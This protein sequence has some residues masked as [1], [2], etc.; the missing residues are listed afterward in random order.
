MQGVTVYSSDFGLKLILPRTTYHPD[1]KI[2]FEV[3][4]ENPHGVLIEFFTLNLTQTTLTLIRKKHRFSASS[5]NLSIKS[6]TNKIASQSSGHGFHETSWFG[7]IQIPSPILPTMLGA[8]PSRPDIIEVRYSLQVYTNHDSVDPSK[9]SS[10][11]QS[12]S[13][14]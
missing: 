6:A 7:C 10:C 3:K 5:G 4:V 12:E 14:I 2:P 8:D 9:M 13:L 1:D 11:I